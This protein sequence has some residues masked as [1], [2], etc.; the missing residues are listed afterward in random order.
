MRLDVTWIEPEVVDCVA[1]IIA[2]VGRS[3]NPP[4]KPDAAQ[5]IQA[6]TRG[7]LQWKQA[8]NLVCSRFQTHIDPQ[9]R[10]FYFVD[11]LT[12]RLLLTR[13]LAPTTTSSITPLERDVSTD[14]ISGWPSSTTKSASTISH[15]CI[16]SNLHGINIALCW[17]LARCTCTMWF[18]VCRT[19]CLKTFG[20][21][22][23]LLSLI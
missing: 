7:R 11:S 17:Q 10:L 18:P 21:F 20:L 9:T 4:L 22:C 13:P 6:L 15:V 1:A 8:V 12:G 19:A 2:N 3:F 16:L 23:D 5:Q 14:L